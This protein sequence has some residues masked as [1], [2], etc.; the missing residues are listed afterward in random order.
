MHTPF[1]M[2]RFIDVIKKIL[3]E[4]D[5]T[6]TWGIGTNVSGRTDQDKKALILYNHINLNESF[7]KLRNGITSDILSDYFGEKQVNQ[8]RQTGYSNFLLDKA[9]GSIDFFHP[10]SGILPMQLCM[11][12]YPER[13]NQYSKNTNKSLYKF[14]ETFSESKKSV[15]VKSQQYNVD[16]R[17]FYQN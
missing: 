7:I 1:I 9:R 3:K 15:I 11:N 8:E 16:T 10:L 12:V 5:F 14:N 6:F 2:V 17:Y 13:K 4:D